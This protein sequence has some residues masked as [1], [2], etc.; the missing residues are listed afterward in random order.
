ML[1][2]VGLLLFVLCL[3]VAGSLGV[4]SYLVWSEEDGARHPGFERWCKRHPVVLAIACQPGSARAVRR[5]LRRI[6][7]RGEF[8]NQE[9]RAPWPDYVVKLEERQLRP[10]LVAVVVAGCRRFRRR[11]RPDVSQLVSGLGGLGALRRASAAVVERL[12]VHGQLVANRLAGRRR[13]VD[14]DRV[15]WQ[16]RLDD[17]G[18][19]ELEEATIGTPEWLSHGA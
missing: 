19:L 9:G 10:D 5:A 3:V 16:G 4:R 8:V 1:L 7:G 2:V 17:T 18:R 15:G 6:L 11:R 12:W 14:R 13:E